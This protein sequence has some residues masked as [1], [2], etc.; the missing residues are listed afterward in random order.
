MDIGSLFQT[1]ENDVQNVANN[2]IQDGVPKLISDAEAQGQTALKSLEVTA[3]GQV[4]TAVQNDIQNGGPSNPVSQFLSGF[5]GKVA[6]D[7]GLH[8]YGL[9]IIAGVVVVA[10]AAI[11]LSKRK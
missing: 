8:Q 3:Q 11:F 10:G 6:Q 1:A 4:E 7:V 9:Y 2:F 5:F